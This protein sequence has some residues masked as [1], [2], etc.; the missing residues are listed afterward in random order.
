[1]TELLSNTEN[2]YSTH[3]HTHTHIH[4]HTLEHTHTHTHIHTYIHTYIHTDEDY[5][6]A[7]YKQVSK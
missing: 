5:K 6:V 4:T 3:T 2:L 1:M 7:N